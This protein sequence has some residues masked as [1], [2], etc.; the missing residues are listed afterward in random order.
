MA[1]AYAVLF[2]DQA[3][4]S[5]QGRLEVKAG[6]HTLRFLS[7]DRLSRRYP[8]LGGAS[9]M[10]VRCQD[11]EATRAFLTAQ[12]IPL[13]AAAGARLVIAPEHAN[14]TVLEFVED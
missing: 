7:T 11:L 4:Q 13:A 5:G 1:Q 12:G 10:T 2:G 14:G 3:V 6:P 8:A 9:V